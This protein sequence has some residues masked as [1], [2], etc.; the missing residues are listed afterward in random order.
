[1][2]NISLDEFKVVFLEN[3]S[4]VLREIKNCFRVL[5]GK[6]IKSIDIDEGLFY[7]WNYYYI[8]ILNKNEDV[9]GRVIYNLITN[10]DQMIK[11]DDRYIYN[12]NTR[13]LEVSKEFTKDWIE[14]SILEILEYLYKDEDYNESLEKDLARVSRSY[15][16]IIRLNI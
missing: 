2:Q 12:A 10:F 3:K 14:K 13:N 4:T 9:G 6:K 15:K 5:S 1:M 7:I 11:K 16:N 8:E